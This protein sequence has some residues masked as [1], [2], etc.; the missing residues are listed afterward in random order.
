MGYPQTSGLLTTAYQ[1]KDGYN[2]VYFID[3]FTPG[4][5]RVIRDKPGMT[6][7]D[8]DYTTMETYSKDGEE[9]TIETAYVLFTP[10]RRAGAVRHCSPIVDE[11]GNIYFKNDS[12][13]LMRLSSRI[14]GWRSPSSRTRTT[15][16]KD[17]TFDA[18]GLKVTA[19]YANG[20]TKDVS[21]Y[22]KYTTDP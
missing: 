12:A 21:D 9:H 11:E 16:S 6:E 5:L 3:N 19:H 20:A 8:H 7:V 10:R 1:D 14:T 13:Q 22:L 2:Y 18:K 15:Y 17:D 4:K